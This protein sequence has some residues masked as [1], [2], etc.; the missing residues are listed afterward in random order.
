M[1]WLGV[2][3]VV[4]VVHQLHGRRLRRRGGIHRHRRR[5]RSRGP[6]SR[7]YL[8]RRRPIAHHRPE[9][10]ATLLRHLLLVLLLLDDRRQWA[11]PP[12]P[13]AKEHSPLLRPPRPFATVSPGNRIRWH[14]SY[15]GFPSTHSHSPPVPAPFVAHRH[16]H[17]RHR[18]SRDSPRRDCVECVD[19]EAD[20]NSVETQ[21]ASGMNNVMMKNVNYHSE[22]PRP[23]LGCDIYSRQSISSRCLVGWS[24]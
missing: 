7:W 8:L 13:S 18:R 5:R 1:D 3:V 24:L 22:N 20:A 12:H 4:V 23:L 21:D 19:A 16:H 6:T 15:S 9:R 10:P 2:V 17:R 11:K 14:R